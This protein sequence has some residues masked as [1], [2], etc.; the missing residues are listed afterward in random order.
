MR[1]SLILVRYNADNILNLTPLRLPLNELRGKL[2][3]E[4]GMGERQIQATQSASE[5]WGLSFGTLLASV[6]VLSLE[7]TWRRRE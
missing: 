3:G 1:Q 4:F 5:H 2:G 6:L 7:S